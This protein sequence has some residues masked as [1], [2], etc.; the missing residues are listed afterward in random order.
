MT[1]H[2]GLKQ[3]A[4]I[5]LLIG[6]LLIAGCA[7]INAPLQQSGNVDS[8]ILVLGKEVYDANCASCHGLQGEGQPNWKEADENG[9]RPAPPH[10]STGHTWHHRD[11]LL[12]EIIAHGVPVEGSTMKGYQEI[13]S[14]EEMEASL[15]YIKT[16]WG[17][18][19][20]KF[21]RGLSAIWR[22]S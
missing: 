17:E 7:T 10:D 1:R 2:L 4:Y 19:E 18:E 22:I 21:H 6:Y 13:L 9:V 5:A 11:S 15:E 12:M 14:Q 20:R 3:W 16:F 8:S